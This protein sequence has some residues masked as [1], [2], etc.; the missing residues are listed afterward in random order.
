LDAAIREIKSDIAG[1]VKKNFKLTGDQ[2]ENLKI[3][4]NDPDTTE[5]FALTCIRALKKRQDISVVFTEASEKK[6]PNF[7]VSWKSVS[8]IPI[9]ASRNMKIAAACA[10]AG[11]A[12]KA[13]P[14][15]KARP[16]KTI[17]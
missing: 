9:P 15:R 8:H 6:E 2:L 5:L 3:K 10:C 4:F 7:K 17:L 16:R 12:K 14:N 13:R 1:F 11:N